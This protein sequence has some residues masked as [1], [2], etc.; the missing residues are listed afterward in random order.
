MESRA[1][2][3][4]TESASA[5]LQEILSSEQEEAVDQ[6]LRQELL[7]RHSV[8]AQFQLTPVA[9]GDRV[10]SETVVQAT[11]RDDLVT[12]PR[13]PGEAQWFTLRPDSRSEALRQLG[14]LERMYAERQLSNVGA[15]TTLQQVFDEYLQGNYSA[16]EADDLQ[17]LEAALQITTWLEPFAIGAPNTAGIERRLSIRRLLYPM[18]RLT[19]GFMGRTSELA[20]LRSFVGVLDPQSR[21]EAVG[22]FLSS[23]ANLKSSPLMLYG[24]G[25]V[26]KSTLLAEFIRQHVTS[27][28][29]FPWVYL[30]F[31]NP[32]LNVAA[33]S[34]IIEEAAEQLRAQYAGSN[35]TDL[36]NVVGDAK[37]PSAQ[38][39]PRSSAPQVSEQGE[40]S[41]LD[42]F[43]GILRF[44][45]QGPEV[46]Q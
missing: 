45:V 46:A 3:W 5:W 32:R 15:P 1:S 33:L 4:T 25:G 31:D 2:I 29:P 9:S 28:V 41:F 26:G 42:H 38:V 18:E 39:F 34:T 22:R 7:R 35:W 10:I 19:S 23:L 27:P 43:L 37:D 21:A 16:G 20:T 6:R 17:R 13:V 14:T 44:E 40:E 12:L 30:D 24:I 11:L 8:L 36:A